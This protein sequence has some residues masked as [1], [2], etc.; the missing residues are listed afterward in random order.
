M[1]PD[2]DKFLSSRKER[3]KGCTDGELDEL[4]QNQN[5][6]HLPET[7]Y[8]LMSAMGKS[9]IETLLDGNATCHGIRDLKNHFAKSHPQEYW[10]QDIF[11]FF[12]HQGEIFYFFR[13]TGE[14]DP[15][16]YS[17]DEETTFFY[18]LAD[19]ISEFFLGEI[20]PE[21]EE[22]RRR[23]ER[24]RNIVFRYSAE[25]DEFYGDP[26]PY[27]L[28]T[29]DS[30]MEYMRYRFRFVTG[31][32]DAE[33]KILM[34]AQNIACIPPLFHQILRLMGKIGIDSLLGGK[35]TYK[36]LIELKR[37][38]GRLFYES[39]QCP[40]DIFVF[41]ADYLESDFYLFRTKDC[42]NDPSVYE[43]R[44]HLNRFYRLADSVT[45]FFMQKL[46][47]DPIRKGNRWKARR[48]SEYFYDPE[49]DQILLRI[50]P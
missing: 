21:R 14:A 5:V 35:S 26:H 32:S 33:I 20:E 39:N 31:C 34:E 48:D 3:Y 11:V 50:A 42:N 19:S 37:R 22:I 16:V 38:N 36:H 8:Q 13:T 27:D 41:Y 43:F 9:G 15:A 24:L 4:K 10:P 46:D 28:L 18:K 7:Y 2:L 6:D 49:V 12:D 25:L 29:P 47:Y 44:S 30:L 23:K 17:A 40:R 45:E 1:H